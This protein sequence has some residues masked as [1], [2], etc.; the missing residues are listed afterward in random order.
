MLTVSICGAPRGNPVFQGD[1]PTCRA[2][3]KAAEKTGLHARPTVTS[4]RPTAYALKQRRLANQM[5]PFSSRSLSSAWKEGEARPTH[6]K[7]PKAKHGWKTGVDSFADVWP[8]IEGWLIAEPTVAT[9]ELMGR[10][11]TMVPDGYA[12]EAQLRTLQ[13]HVKVWRAEPV[14]EMV[15]RS[16]RKCADTPTEV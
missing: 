10:L 12:S 1:R 15:L 13:R 2:Y 7:Q 3:A 14:K 11:A 8:V 9:H 4:S 5:L 16:L 6:R